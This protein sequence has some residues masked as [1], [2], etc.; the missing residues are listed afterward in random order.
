MMRIDGINLINGSTATG[1]VL[2]SGIS[3][4]TLP[5]DGLGFRLTVAVGN[6][7]PGVYWFD[8][9]ANDWYN[10]EISGI[11][12]GNGLVGGGNFGSIIVELDP[13]ILQG[14]TGPQGPMGVSGT[15]GVP[16]NL[17]VVL[18]QNAAVLIKTQRV[19]AQHII[20]SQP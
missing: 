15:D 14:I 3:F 4:P 8:G 12:A 9:T 17:D 20:S 7:G 5:R 1:L 16:L 13:T 10:G 11:V 6:Y 19:V 18:I 2:E